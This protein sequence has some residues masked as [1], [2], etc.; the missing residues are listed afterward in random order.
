M[1]MHH[2]VAWFRNT[3][4]ELVWEETV[5]TTG[6]RAYTRCE[7]QQYGW[8]KEYQGGRFPAGGVINPSIDFPDH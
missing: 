5:Q 3:I 6:A 4:L 7:K 1:A 8:G 2:R